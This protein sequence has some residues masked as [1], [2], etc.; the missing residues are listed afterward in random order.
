MCFKCLV[1]LDMSCN[2]ERPFCYR[3]R[4][5]GR[6]SCGVFLVDFWCLCGCVGFVCV[7]VMAAF[8]CVVLLCGSSWLSSAI[9]IGSI[10][11][12]DNIVGL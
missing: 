6:G 11:I 2:P 5:F 9:V 1:P 8:V 7:F 3:F 10:L 12:R 4:C